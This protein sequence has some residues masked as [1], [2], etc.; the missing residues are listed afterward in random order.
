MTTEKD[1][2]STLKFCK[3]QNEVAAELQKQAAY[4]HLY[5][6]FNKHPVLLT[7]H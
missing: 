6:W 3:P 4:K 2:N 5:L 7:K 1:L